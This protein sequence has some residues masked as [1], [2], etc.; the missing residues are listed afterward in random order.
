MHILLDMQSCQ[1]ES[2]LRGIGRY[3]LSLA[4]AIIKNPANHKVSLLLNGLYPNNITNAVKEEFRGII[5]A[6]QIYTFC[7]QGPIAYHDPSNRSR[8][9]AAKISRDMAIANISPDII[10]NMSFSEGFVDDFVVSISEYPHGARQFSIV[11]DLIPLLNKSIYLVDPTFNDFYMKKLKEFE[12]ADGL[13]AISASAANEVMQYTA[14]SHERITNISSAIDDHFKVI[15]LSDDEQK[16]LLEKYNIPNDFIM[17]IGVLEPRKNIEA[18]IH[19]YALLPESIRL[20]HTLV[21]ACQIKPIDRE[22]LLGIAKKYS[23]NDNDIAFTGFIPDKEL[24]ALYNICKLFVFPSIHEGFGLPPLEAMSCGAP[25]IAS[26]TTSLPE[27]MG[28]HEAMFDPRDVDEMSELIKK[29]LTDESFNK[30]LITNGMKQAALFSWDNCAQLALNAFE[31]SLNNLPQISISSEEALSI[32]I[33]KINALDNPVIEEVDKLGVAWAL[34]RNSFKKHQKK[35]L[36]DISVLVQHDARTGI[37]RVVR[38]VLSSMI[39]QGCEGYEI[40]PVYC[41]M[42][43][44]FHYANKYTAE[45]F[46]V[47][48]G[49]SVDE[50]ALITKDDIFVGLDLTAHLFPYLN[51]QLDSIRRAGAKVYY[52]VYDLIPLIHPEWTDVNV[53][54]AF[55]NWISS[56]VEHA[57]G[58][59]CISESVATELKTWIVDNKKNIRPNPF[60]Q[61]KHFHLGADMSASSPSTGRPKNA[62]SLLIQLR[63]NPVFLMVS[64]I[65]PR[66]GHSQV[67]AAFENL[68]QRGEECSLVIVGKKGW[69]IDELTDKISTHD[70]LNNKL[71]WLEGISDDFL[72]EVYA[73][74]QALIVASLAEGFGLPIIEAAQQGLPI[75]ARDIPVLR[76]V[77]GDNAFYFSGNEPEYL[78]LA[79]LEWLQLYKNKLEPKSTSIPWLTWRESTQQLLAQLPISKL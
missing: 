50:P 69:G 42:G 49:T 51:N 19:A 76:E 36:I 47:D 7:A 71:F 55:P 10:C 60:L 21:L 26:N 46:G 24:I 2:R 17:T 6:D 5:P 37:Q 15:S 72:S 53:R 28:W 65:E 59:V 31:K 18:L 57:D 23:L 1:S 16:R 32:A 79:I 40:R 61:I 43:K 34:A 77:A 39:E 20:N 41:E 62:D 56:L 14:V 33:N 3:S 75:I 45:K 68:W 44:L 54:A 58:I 70:E 74:S 4:K 63:K 73:L 12:K 64:T 35:I 29:A 48:Y 38:S 22:R 27:V 9:V 78:E 66:K 67:L 52:I 11:Y 30:A 8:N 13:L 25:T